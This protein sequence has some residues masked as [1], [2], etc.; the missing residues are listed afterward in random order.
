MSNE[1]LTTIGI[2]EREHH[3]PDADYRQVQRARSAARSRALASGSL[4]ARYDGELVDL[5]EEVAPELGTLMRQAEELAAEHAKV[6]T[7]AEEA[8]KAYAAYPAT[9]RNELV[10]ARIDGKK[11]PPDREPE[12]KAKV[13][14]LTA[15]ATGLAQ[16]HLALVQ[17][18]DNLAIE[19]APKVHDRGKELADEASSIAITHLRR[20]VESLAQARVGKVAIGWAHSPGGRTDPKA[21]KAE[22]QIEASVASLQHFLDSE[23][24]D[25]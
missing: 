19:A 1:Q 4:T 5:I 24:E 23:T 10:N 20:A 3:V 17:Q 21:T 12:L 6:R 16:R 9:R 13:T 2:V 8:R 22:D 18:I 7:E 25:L 15:T 14:D 11:T